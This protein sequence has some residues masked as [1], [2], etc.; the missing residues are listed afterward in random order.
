MYVYGTE[1]RV[2]ESVVEHSSYWAT[3]LSTARIAFVPDTSILARDD[4]GT[5]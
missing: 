1:E 5:A 4:V 3:V 2:F